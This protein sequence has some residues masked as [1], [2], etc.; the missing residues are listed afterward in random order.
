MNRLGFF[1]SNFL[2]EEEDNYPILINKIDVGLQNIKLIK[3]ELAF[4]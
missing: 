2:G 1:L 4:L 3:S